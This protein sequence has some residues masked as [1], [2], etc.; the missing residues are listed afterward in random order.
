MHGGA[1]LG[2]SMALDRASIVKRK[3]TQCVGHVK[4]YQRITL[5]KNHSA[6][7]PATRNFPVGDMKEHQR[8]HYAKEPFSC[9]RCN[10]KF[11]LQLLRIW[12]E[13]CNL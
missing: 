10:K 8:T 5:I 2:V 7:Q 9:S 13:I 3:F 12:Q 1:P 11:T 6:A 4:E